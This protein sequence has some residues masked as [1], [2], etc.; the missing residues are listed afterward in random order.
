MQFT[1]SEIARSAMLLSQRYGTTALALAKKRH[2]DLAKT[3]DTVGAGVWQRIVEA[4]ER[5]ESPVH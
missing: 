3:D 2:R 4:L 5:I 1:E